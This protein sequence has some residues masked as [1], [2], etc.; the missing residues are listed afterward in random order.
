MHFSFFPFGLCYND[1]MSKY[2]KTIVTCAYIAASICLLL[3]AI[4]LQS[5]FLYV[6][7][8]CLLI[9]VILRRVSSSSSSS[10]FEDQIEE[11]VRT[12][13][14]HSSNKNGSK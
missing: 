11:A 1:D 9:G 8:A 14:D 5:I 7:I 6:G 2:S 10:S 13:D 12:T 3:F 4:N